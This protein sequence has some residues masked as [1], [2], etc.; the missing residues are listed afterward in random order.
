MKN[1]IE[2]VLISVHPSSKPLIVYTIG[3]CCILL[4]KF[5]FLHELDLF[6]NVWRS[7]VVIG[8]LILLYLHFSRITT[9]Y[10]LTN[11]DITGTTGILAKHTVRVPLN[12]I[13]NYETK[14]SLLCRIF[15]LG[16]LLIDTAGNKENEL[17]MLKLDNSNID[18]IISQL[19]TI[20]SQ[21][22]KI[23]KDQL[24]KQELAA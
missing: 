5:A 18:L 7:V 14:R 1:D 13:T 15:G 11:T 9:V 20:F 8:S 21:R 16:N 22:N 17:Q 2:N 6:P 10:N 24:S 23:E 12:R 4:I 3:F 19:K